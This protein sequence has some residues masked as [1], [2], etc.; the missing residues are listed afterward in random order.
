MEKTHIIFM[1]TDDYS[2]GAA[3]YFDNKIEIWASPLDME[4]RGSHRWLQNVI[5]HEFTHIV[6]MQ[7]AMKFGR[8]VPGG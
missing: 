7:A 6:S 1:D 5:T 3:Y 4:L 2:N 8:S